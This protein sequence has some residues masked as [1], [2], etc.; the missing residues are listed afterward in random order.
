M[1][2]VAISYTFI[3]TNSNGTYI[4]D[5]GKVYKGQYKLGVA[6]GKHEVKLINGTVTEA[7]TEKSNASYKWNFV[8]C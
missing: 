2:E 7:C 5:N 8:E 3:G 4:Y 1:I 6:I